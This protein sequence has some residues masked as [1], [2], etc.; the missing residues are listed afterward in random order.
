MLLLV[1]LGCNIYLTLVGQV[2]HN[3]GTKVAKNES[4][5]HTNH[6]PNRGAVAK[7]LQRETARAPK[8]FYLS[9]C[10]LHIWESLGDVLET[11]VSLSKSFRCQNFKTYMVF[12]N[13]CHAFQEL[14]HGD[15]G[16]AV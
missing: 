6:S 12:A 8:Q 16:S 14:L 10:Q 2:S 5:I 15:P 3:C 1:P 4:K 13:A 7:I 9:I 11:R